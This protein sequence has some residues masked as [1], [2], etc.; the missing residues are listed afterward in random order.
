MVID[1]SDGASWPRVYE[2]TLKYLP[3]IVILALAAGV[4]QIHV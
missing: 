1:E 2:S 3:E 4:I